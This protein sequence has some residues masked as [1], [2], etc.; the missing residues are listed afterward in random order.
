MGQSDLELRVEEL[1]IPNCLEFIWQRFI[2]RFAFVAMDAR[3]ES[4][5]KAP[6]RPC[7]IS[8]RI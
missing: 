1:S 7:F 5:V 8:S 2:H 3:K 6:A 4:K